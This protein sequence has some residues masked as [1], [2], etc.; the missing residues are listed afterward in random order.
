MGHPWPL[1][2]GAPWLVRGVDARGEVR[3]QPDIVLGDGHTIRFAID[4]KYKRVDPEADVY[5][6][7]AYA[8]A[9]NLRRIALVYPADGEVAP[10]THRI[11]NDDVSILVR[12]VPV[13]TDAAGFVG[14][15]LR[16]AQAARD[17][18]RELD[19]ALAGREAACPS[20]PIRRAVRNAASRVPRGQDTQPR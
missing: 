4:A 8:K 10:A 11:R 20:R 12:T 5:Q 7:L 9:L 19:G 1:P 14:L 2:P 18:F 15:D 3:I 17:P 6:A 16:A 13:G